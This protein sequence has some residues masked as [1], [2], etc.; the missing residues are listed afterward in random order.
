MP[1]TLIAIIL[2]I[3]YNI[4]IEP[5]LSMLIILIIISTLVIISIISNKIIIKIINSYKV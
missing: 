1:I 2:Y 5:T 3:T 4:I